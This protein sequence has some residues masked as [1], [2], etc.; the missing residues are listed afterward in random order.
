MSLSIKGNSAICWWFNAGVGK[1]TTEHK[2]LHTCHNS[3]HKMCEPDIH[4][5]TKAGK[6]YVLNSAVVAVIHYAWLTGA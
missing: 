5:D 2:T 3:K 1:D 6:C 4:S